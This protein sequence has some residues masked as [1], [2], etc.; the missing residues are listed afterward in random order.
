MNKSRFIIVL[1]GRECPKD[2]RNWKGD[3]RAEGWYNEVEKYQLLPNK[4][5]ASMELYQQNRN[6]VNESIALLDNFCD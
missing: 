3:S 6:A 1:D 4:E 5:A 2:R